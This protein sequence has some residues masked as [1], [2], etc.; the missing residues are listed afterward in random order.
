MVIRI[1]VRREL[2]EYLADGPV[3]ECFRLL[4]GKLSL[5]HSRRPPAEDHT[6]LNRVHNIDDQRT[7]AIDTYVNVGFRGSAA[8]VII[9]VSNNIFLVRDDELVRD[10]QL[11]VAA[12]RFEIPF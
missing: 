5:N 3:D 11:G 9:V 2:P 10:K 4:R 8:P 1:S 12:G 7:L 6:V